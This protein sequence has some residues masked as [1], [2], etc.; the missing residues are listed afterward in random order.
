[1]LSK[2]LKAEATGWFGMYMT[3]S[4][5]CSVS[6]HG[7]ICWWTNTVEPWCS[8]AGQDETAPGRRLS[9]ESLTRKSKHLRIGGIWW[10]LFVNGWLVWPVLDF[11]GDNPTA[12]LFRILHLEDPFSHWQDDGR[13]S[14]CRTGW[15]VPM[16]F[17]I[18]R[19][20]TP[21]NLKKQL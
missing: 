17:D 9:L 4:S 12:R 8:P 11:L 6:D 5:M 2:M 16:V 1:M 10:S 21:R 3:M 14:S 13:G 15:A 19:F 7:L 20:H 18:A